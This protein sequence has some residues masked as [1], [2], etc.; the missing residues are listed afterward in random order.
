RRS[1][2]T[3]GRSRG[4]FS[5]ARWPERTVRRPMGTNDLKQSIPPGERTLA[6]LGY[7]KVGAPLPGAWETWYYV[8]EATFLNQLSYLRDNGW[9]VIDL[10]TLLQGLADPTRLPQR[11]ALITFDDGY[12]CVLE[13][14]LPCLL[15][16][17][18][19]AVHFVPT[20]YI[21][22]RNWFDQGAEPEEPI[23]A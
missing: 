3:R 7:H 6:I 1:T 9:Q 13:V 8:P 20:D 15:R 2:S 22:G 4:A 18:Y 23:C 10:E 17:G 19:P 21:G 12:R 11:A 16:F 14:A 5:N